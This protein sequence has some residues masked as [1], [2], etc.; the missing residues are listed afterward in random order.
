MLKKQAVANIV[1]NIMLRTTRRLRFSKLSPYT[2]PL[3]S[4]DESSIMLGKL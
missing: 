1:I 2:P 4:D 3:D